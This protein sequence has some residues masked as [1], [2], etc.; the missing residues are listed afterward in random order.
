MDTGSSRNPRATIFAAG[1]TPPARVSP[2]VS[3]R[4]I[5]VTGMPAQRGRRERCTPGAPK[6]AG[7]CGGV[8][9]GGEGRYR[10]ERKE[11]VAGP[12][13]KG[14]GERKGRKKEEEREAGPGAA[15][16]GVRF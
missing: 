5:R 6:N 1:L 16:P 15:G 14:E 4:R 12:M 7:A 11:R 13:H 8:I 2:G 10:K 9:E 3:S